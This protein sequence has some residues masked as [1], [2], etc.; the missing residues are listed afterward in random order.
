MIDKKTL[1]QYAKLSGLRPWQAEKQ[2]V[3]SAILAVLSDEALVFKGGTYL[4]FFHGLD[5]FSED[6]DF[7]QNGEVHENI[8]DE[9]VSGLRLLGIESRAKKTNDDARSLG[10]RI[11]AQGP[12]HTA[13]ADIC[14][15]YVDISRREALGRPAAAYPLDRP[16]FGLP[17][18]LVQGMDLD[19]MAAEKVRAILTRE[20]ALD[21]Y[22]LAFLINRK[23]ARFS[24]ELAE[25]KLEWYG[26]KFDAAEVRKKLAARE[27]GFEA[28]IT[29][30][31][32]GKKAGFKACR[33]AIL[34]W[35]EE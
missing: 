29:P 30:L 13:Q 9:I 31:L 25:K 20:K 11:S 2:Y 22:D 10:F 21:A 5:R 19:E 12:L 17:L 23:K 1:E 35:L 26:L 6:L 16:A 8:G 34:D 18:K 24:K 28:E 32:F 4:W 3:Q 14:H 33:S 7:T 15:V 27:K